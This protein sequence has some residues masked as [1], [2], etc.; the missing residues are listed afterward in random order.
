MHVRRISGLGATAGGTA[1]E[2]YDP[3]RPSWLP[4]WIPT[5]SEIACQMGITKPVGSQFPSPVAAG[6]PTVPAVGT[7]KLSP[8]DEVAANAAVLETAT[9]AH[10]TYVAAQQQA[11]TDWETEQAATGGYENVFLGDLSS[12]LGTYKWWLIG[13]AVGVTALLVLSKR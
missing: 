2:C 13:G 5:N 11:I 6:Y 4:V 9:G 12:W 8:A 10:E 1:A 7:T 3:Q